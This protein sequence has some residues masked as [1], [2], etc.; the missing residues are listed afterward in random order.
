[1]LGIGCLVILLTRFNGNKFYLN[2]E[3][4]RSVE[5]TPDTVITLTSG[6]KILVKDSV[7]EVIKK[8]IIYKRV[9]LNPDL[10]IPSGE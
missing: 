9:I 4:I 8:I 1:M 6:E 10:E 3:L 7:K 2:A 5:S